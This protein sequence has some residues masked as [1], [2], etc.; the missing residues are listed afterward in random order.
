MSLFQ[1]CLDLEIPSDI[2]LSPDGQTVIYTTGLLWGHRKGEHTLSTIWRAE[3]G[4]KHSARHL[5]SGQANDRCPRISPDGK[6]VAFISDRAK[7]GE[8]SAVYILPLS[9]GEAYPITPTE[10]KQGIAKISFSPD[11][12]FIAFLSADEKS[13]ERK[14]RDEETGDVQVWGEDWELNRLRVVHVG[15]KKITTLVS[16]DAHISDFSWSDDGEQIATMEQ[17]TPDIEMT[18]VG[19]RT[20]SLVDTA[21]KESRMLCTFPTYASQILWAGDRL[22]LIGA[23]VTDVAMA[24]NAVYSI[25]LNAKE[26]TYTKEAHGDEN[27]APLLG[28]VGKDVIV[29][30]LHGP[31]DS[32]RMLKGR[33]LFAKPNH[34]GTWAAAYPKDSDELVLA[35]AQG[36]IN[37][38]TEVYTTTASGGSM[39][40]LSNHG[41]AFAGKTL[42]TVTHLKHRTLDDKEELD[43]M[44]LTPTQ[45][46]T[47]KDGDKPTKPLPTVVAIHGGPYYRRTN[48]FDTINFYWTPLLLSAGYGVLVPNYRGSSGYGEKLAKY[49]RGGMG[50]YDEP[51]IVAATQHAIE[52]G[53]ADKEHLIVAGYSQGGFLSYLSAVRNGQHAFGWKFRAAIPGAG[54]S[55]WRT[56]ALTSDIGVVESEMTGY[57]PW[58]MDLEDMGDRQGSALAELKAA[59]EKGGVVPPVLMLHGERD[60]RVPVEQAKGFRRGLEYWGLPCEYVV[61]PREDHLF[62][63]QRHVRDMVERIV[64]FVDRHIGGA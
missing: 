41:H 3:T 60:V 6:S 15:T 44:Y 30:V 49:S 48:T 21:T 12:K 42:G 18:F 2:Q 39:V 19:K 59:A 27:C 33:T 57:G 20:L 31:E 10:H 23:A 35:I 25:D 52:Q 9:G 13:E 16:K 58:S 7:A 37:T 8:S 54:V 32:L 56:M 50:K 38:P 26:A 11:G 40:Q 63:E 24:A 4:K 34:I 28:K 51:D 47:S 64:A 45:S 14:K 61:Y 36:D 55:D 5:T 53:F 17:R 22:Y 1:D 46:P 29:H 43:A 62:A